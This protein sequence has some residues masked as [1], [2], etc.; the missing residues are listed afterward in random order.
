MKWNM[1]EFILLNIYKVMQNE[2]N[3]RRICGLYVKPDT[4]VA[5]NF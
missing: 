2:Q 5:G 4:G 1:I 3:K